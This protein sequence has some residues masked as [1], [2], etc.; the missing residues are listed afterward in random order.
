MN[1]LISGTAA[2]ARVSTINPRD[3]VRDLIK[4]LR[5][6]Y[7]RASEVELAKRLVDVLEED[8]DALLIAA[9]FIVHVI[10]GEAAAR[11]RRRASGASHA[12]HRVEVKAQ[13]AKLAARVKETVL[14]D[15]IM[16]NGIA[17]RYC[18]G[19]Q[20]ADFGKAYEKIAERVGAAMVGEIMCEAEVRAL[21]VVAA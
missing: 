15:L 16:P 17:M 9:Q 3:G 6:Q 2:S 12:E 1:N 11:S 7:K 13:A 21:L 20:M 5:A 4:E 19:T 8:H 10:T 18:S 14:L